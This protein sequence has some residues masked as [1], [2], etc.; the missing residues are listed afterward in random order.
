MRAWN[1]KKSLRGKMCCCAV[2][3]FRIVNSDPN[4]IHTG[5]NMINYLSKRCKIKDKNIPLRD[6]LT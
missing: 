4:W 3:I 1:T 6:S 5:K 2:G